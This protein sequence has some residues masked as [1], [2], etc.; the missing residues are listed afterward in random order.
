MLSMQSDPGKHAGRAV[1]GPQDK[2]KSGPP[3]CAPRGV[4]PNCRI[5]ADKSGRE[6]IEP[7]L[8]IRSDYFTTSA[9]RIFT[10]ET[11]TSLIPAL[12]PV[13]TAAIL[14]TTSSPF[15]TRPKTQ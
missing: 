6:E 8:G 3:K 1:A 9:L 2:K 5:S 12:R 14:S 7:R 10:V 4:A 11:G 15:T 13:A